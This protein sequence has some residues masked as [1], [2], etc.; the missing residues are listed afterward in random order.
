LLVKKGDKIKVTGEGAVKTKE[1]RTDT[2]KGKGK[3]V[4]GAM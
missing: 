4:G 2:P 1:T 3:R